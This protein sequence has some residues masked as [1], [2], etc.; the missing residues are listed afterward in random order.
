M[1]SFTQLELSVYDEDVVFVFLLNGT[2]FYVSITSKMLEGSGELLQE[3]QGFKDDLDDPE[4]MFNF[5]E[6]VLGALGD[7]IRQVTPSPA[8]GARQQI[9]LLDYFSPPTF[10]FE[11]VNRDGKLC[12]LRENYNPRIHGDTAPRTRIVQGS[13]PP[14][15]QRRGSDSSA[16][17]RGSLPGQGVIL[18]SAL[19]DVPLVPASQLERVDDGLRDEQL[20]DIPSKVRRVGTSKTFFFKAAL[21]A[22]GHR[23]E[24]DILSR[25]KRGG[26]FD[27][28]FRTSSLAS[29]VV[30]EDNSGEDKATL[31][32]FLLEY[33]E[34]GTLAERMEA[35]PVEMR[36]KWFHQVQSTVGR[37]HE[38]GIVWGD[39]KPDNIIINVEGDAVVVDF[40]GG[41]TPE[42][43]E[44]ELQ[45]T[46]QGDLIAL[47]HMADVLGLKSGEWLGF[48]AS[49]G[50]TRRS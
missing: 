40:G 5:E 12:T 1:S 50:L 31:M 28:T 37:L 39:V 43:I 25:I 41:F 30:W 16:S 13:P 29:L 22:H 44:P 18:R 10:A 11:L 36:R 27:S 15:S 42:Y 9:T 17:S 32:G 49:L 4:T 45:Q 35:A 48:N 7:D 33:V 6:W 26:P 21:K 47:D 8:P 2:R 38:L 20:S 46:L 14:M 3:F 34:G 19:P 23:R 24:M